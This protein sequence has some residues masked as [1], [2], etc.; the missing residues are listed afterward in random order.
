[1]IKLKQLLAKLC[2][3]KDAERPI[4]LQLLLLFV[5]KERILSTHLRSELQTFIEFST[6]MVVDV[7]HLYDNFAFAI[8]ALLRTKALDFA[9][10]Q[11]EARRAIPDEADFTRLM[12][13]VFKAVDADRKAPWSWD[14]VKVGG[15]VPF[16]AY[17]DRPSFMHFVEKHQLWAT[18]VE[19]LSAKIVEEAR[20]GGG[21][22]GILT[23]VQSLDQSLRNS[24]PFTRAL[25]YRLLVECP[26]VPRTMWP[27]PAELRTLFTEIAAKADARLQVACLHGIQRFVY[28][29][30][31]PHDRKSMLISLFQELVNTGAVL[32]G[33]LSAWE[34]DLRDTADKNVAHEVVVDVMSKLGSNPLAT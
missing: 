31:G 14:L 1:M 27:Q 22:N 6:D 32:P 10:F 26:K 24:V 2:E 3:C 25:A 21:T 12:V 11:V 4:L 23:W 17:R 33:T 28:E 9:W 34:Q 18:Y 15:P 20:A 5:K 8:A 7:P 16:E 30:A 29:V 19:P 13:A